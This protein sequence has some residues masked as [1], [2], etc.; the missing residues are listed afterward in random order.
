MY[1]KDFGNATNFDIPKFDA[2]SK[3]NSQLPEK[4]CSRLYR[5]RCPVL[6]NASQVLPPPPPLVVEV[7][8][9]VVVVDGVVAGLPI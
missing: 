5:V 1:S 8:P 2:E 4:D 6:L 9:D 3:A 7:D